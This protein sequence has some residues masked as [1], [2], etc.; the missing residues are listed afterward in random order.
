MKKLIILIVSVVLFGT[1][2][3][4]ADEPAAA[5]AAIVKDIKEM[6][7]QRNTGSFINVSGGPAL[8]L[9]EV[10]MGSVTSG[11]PNFSGEVNIGYEWISKKKIG[12]G[13]LYNGYF[14]GVGCTEYTGTTT[15]KL[16]ERWG[17][18]YFAPQ[19]AGRI[20]LKSPK[21]SLRYALGIGMVMSRE[22]VT[23]GDELFGRNY[24]YGYGT[25][26]SFG[27]EFLLTQNIGITGGVKMLDGVIY[28]RYS[29][30][31]N[32]GRIVRVDLDFGI[33]FHF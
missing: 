4:R 20:L 2:A 23:S 13:F 25:N 9:T 27:I 29:G 8:I 28:Q 18:H 17:L 5:E 6:K 3:M 14:T 24:D 7:L 22:V 1:H 30:Q 16:H 26:I 32:D 31:T 15:V 11:S 19:F 12:F 10:D 33:S 21:W